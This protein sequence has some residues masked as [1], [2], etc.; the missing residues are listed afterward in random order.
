MRFVDVSVKLFGWGSLAFGAWGLIH[1]NSL[2][3]LL[4]DDP[5]LGRLAAFHAAGQ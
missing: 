5:S 3:G 1:P 2:T 4:G